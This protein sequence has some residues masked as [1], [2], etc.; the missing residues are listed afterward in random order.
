MQNNPAPPSA[1]T[2]FTQHASFVH[3]VP[4]PDTIY[5]AAPCGSPA[6]STKLGAGSTG[7]GGPSDRMEA[8]SATN[9]ASSARLQGSPNRS[10]QHSRDLNDSCRAAQPVAYPC[11]VQ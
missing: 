5:K 10:T 8:E 6:G 4:Q 11:D 2:N 1:A 3:N 9:A 7:F